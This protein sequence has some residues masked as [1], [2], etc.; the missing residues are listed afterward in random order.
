MRSSAQAI[1]FSVLEDLTPRPRGSLQN[2]ENQGIPELIDDYH[3]Q[4]LETPGI[5]VLIDDYHHQNLV[6]P[7][8]PWFS[9]F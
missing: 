9:K 6:N 3:Y 4:N 1:R 8:I 7:G 2:L 5:P